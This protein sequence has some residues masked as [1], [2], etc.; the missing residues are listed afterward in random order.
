[1][2]DIIVSVLLTIFAELELN[3]SSVVVEFLNVNVDPELR[4]HVLNV[5]C[6]TDPGCADAVPIV[7]R[8]DA[9]GKPAD[10]KDP[11][12]ET[13]DIRVPVDPARTDVPQ[14][15]AAAVDGTALNCQLAS[16]PV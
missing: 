10:R 16:H 11:L 2:L 13:A 15:L 14:T 4:S 5:N 3:E 6:S 1:M 9:P 8:Q 12:V 7:R